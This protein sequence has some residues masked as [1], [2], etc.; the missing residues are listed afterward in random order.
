LDQVEASLQ[1]CRRI[2]GG[3]LSFANN[4]TRT[5]GEGDLGRAIESMTAVLDGRM[6]RSGVELLL[7]VDPA[8]PHVRGSQS[9]LEQL[10]LNLASNACEAMTTGGRLELR[11][12][13]EGEH[14]RAT[15]TD[16]GRGIPA[17][18]LA[19]GREPFFTT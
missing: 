1:V 11:A 10:V 4:A 3:M 16:T 9:D 6:R 14:V 7:D 15:V 2:F 17:E 5:V 13:C 12:W 19:R 8:L 18:H